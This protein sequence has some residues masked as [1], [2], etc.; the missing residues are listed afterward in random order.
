M[1]I[2]CVSREQRRLPAEQSMPLLIEDCEEHGEEVADNDELSV[3]SGSGDDDTALDNAADD[4]STGSRVKTDNNED[5][6]EAHSSGGSNSAHR[7]RALRRPADTES[8][9]SG[10]LARLATSTKQEGTPSQS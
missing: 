6:D 10:V 9:P 8:C 3:G 4:G 5:E 1:N 7:R 2:L